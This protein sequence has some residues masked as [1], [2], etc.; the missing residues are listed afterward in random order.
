MMTW[1]HRICDECWNKK[2]P[3]QRPF[4]VQHQYIE[5]VSCCFCGKNTISGIFVRHD[6]KELSC[7]HD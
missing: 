2:N 7:K 6:P 5:L 3:G 1:T 4:R